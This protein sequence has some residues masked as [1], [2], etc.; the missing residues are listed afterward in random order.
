MF[1]CHW[2]RFWLLMQ[3]M[4]NQDTADL[5]TNIIYL[6][7]QAQQIPQGYIF[8]KLELKVWFLSDNKQSCSIINPSVYTHN[9]KW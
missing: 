6:M 5:K 4:G 7:V 9:K 8:R 3:K 1:N 2:L